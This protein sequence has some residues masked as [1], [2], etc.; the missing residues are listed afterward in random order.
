MEKK[1]IV[2]LTMEE[3][4]EL[5]KLLSNGNAAAKKHRIAKVLLKADLSD[6][7]R[8]TDAEIVEEVDVSAKTVARIRE[9]FVEGGLEN[10]FKKKFTPRYSRRKLDGEG[11]AKLIAICCGEAPEG[12]S[13][14]T[15]KLL[16]KRIVELEITESISED[17]VGRTLKKTNLNLGRK[18]SGV[19]HP[20]RMPN[21]FAKWK[22]C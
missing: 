17:T 3:R 19:F 4:D 7:E 8:Y 16:A 10:V 21:L 13:K 2:K 5:N 1:Y 6:G 11:E 20:K 14:W 18:K 15:L 9:K 22:M 12:R